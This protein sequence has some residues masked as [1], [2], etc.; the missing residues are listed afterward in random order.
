MTISQTLKSRFQ[1]SPSPIPSERT[2]P[3]LIQKTRTVFDQLSRRDQLALVFLMGFLLI[4]GLGFG[5]WKVHQNAQK[6]Q[7]GY[8]TAVADLFWLRS[9]AGNISP[10]QSQALSSGDNI[11]QILAQAGISAQVVDTTGKQQISFSHSQVAVIS[12]VIGQ[13]A[14]QGFKIEQLQ[15]SQVSLDKLEVQAVVSKS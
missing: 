7:K 13:I 2:S 5:G 10:T 14:Q 9:Q 6:V 15:I 1:R 8:E 4:F 11:K 3:V 12:N